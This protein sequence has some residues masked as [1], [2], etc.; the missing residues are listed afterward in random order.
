MCEC[1]IFLTHTHLTYTYAHIFVCKKII[2]ISK[3]LMKVTYYGVCVVREILFF[4]FFLFFL[5]IYLVFTFV[6]YFSLNERIKILMIQPRIHVNTI[7]SLKKK[8]NK[9]KIR[10]IILN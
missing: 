3:Q 7:N 9:Q 1:I 4:S 10:A 8:F 6:S 2:I 5:I